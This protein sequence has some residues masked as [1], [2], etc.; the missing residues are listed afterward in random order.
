MDGHD[1]RREPRTRRGARAPLS[2]LRFGALALLLVCALG[3]LGAACGGPRTASYDDNARGVSITYDAERFGPGTLAASGQIVAAE[4]SMGAEPLAA[5][6]TVAYL[7]EAAA[8]R[9]KVHGPEDL[10]LRTLRVVA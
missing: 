5:G 3:A 8:A 6:E 10:S 9:L 4:E 1:D 7:G 2:H